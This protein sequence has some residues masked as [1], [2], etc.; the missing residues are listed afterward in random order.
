MAVEKNFSVAIVDIEK[1][2]DVNKILFKYA[3][4]V[5]EYSAY[6]Y[7]NLEPMDI[8]NI[9][10]D[11]TLF[12]LCS[13]SESSFDKKLNDLIEELDQLNTLY[14]IRNED[15][16]EMIAEI[17]HILALFIKFDNVE[18]I[19]KGTFEKIDRFHYLKT[20]FGICKS[21]NPHFRPVEDMPIEDKTVEP[22]AIYIFS[23]SEEN[24]SKLKDWVCEKIMEIDSNFEIEIK[25]FMFID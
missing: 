15:T 16:H 4:H 13:Q 17:E 19:K 8:W 7:F 23:D 1:I 18:F 3:T 10:N 11:I 9:K 5:K 20:E 25:P 6:Y 14:A 22:E 24:L 12:Q 21:Y 2:E